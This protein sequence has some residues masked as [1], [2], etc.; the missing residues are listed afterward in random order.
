[1]KRLTLQSA[2]VLAVLLVAALAVSM[3]VQPEK[4]EP[5]KG[6]KI[7]VTG[8]LSCTFCTL[9]HP[10]KPCQKG[11]CTGC[12]KAG[13]PALLTAA[14]GNMYILL[15]NEIKKPVMT[16]ERME[17]AGSKVTVKGLLVKGK[18][19]QAIFVD[20]MDKAEAKAGETKTEPK[21]E[22]KEHQH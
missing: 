11:C 13:D 15:G 16:P 5:I 6:E 20:S 12:I 2:L 4:Q 17:M 10:D 7:N 3:A 22:P 1:M 19:I 8:Q 14:D 9:A 18:G 21:E